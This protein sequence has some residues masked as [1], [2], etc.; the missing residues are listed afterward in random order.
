MDPTYGVYAYKSYKVPGQCKSD[1]HGQRLQELFIFLGRKKG[2]GSRNSDTCTV[3]KHCHSLGLQFPVTHLNISFK[4]NTLLETQD[5][6][7]EDLG[8]ASSSDTS[9]L[10]D[11]SLSVPQ[12]PTCGIM[13]ITAL[14]YITGVL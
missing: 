6:D 5:S 12:F 9:F 7:S 13:G 11:L 1:A 3:L 14:F 2:L 8:S 10:C 4:K